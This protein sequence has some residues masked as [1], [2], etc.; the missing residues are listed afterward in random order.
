[1]A[2]SSSCFVLERGGLMCGLHPF[3]EDDREHLKRIL[4]GL[5]RNK[6][7]NF[8]SGFENLIKLSTALIGG[9]WTILEAQECIA[10]TIKLST[11][12]EQLLRRMSKGV[13]PHFTLGY[14]PVDEKQYPLLAESC[15]LWSQVSEKSEALSI[16]INEYTSFLKPVLPKVFHDSF[17]RQKKQGRPP[18]DSDNVIAMLTVFYWNE[19]KAKPSA[20]VLTELSSCLLEKLSLPFSDPTRRVKSVLSLFRDEKI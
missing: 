5:D 14:I 20:N 18:A 7:E 4:A 10:E 9:E 17:L 1:V 6:T 12:L 8:I 3:T 16:Q 13:E 2:N 15:E 19:F 11:R